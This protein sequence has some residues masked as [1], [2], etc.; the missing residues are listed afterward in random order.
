MQTAALCYCNQY[1]TDGFVPRAV[2]A[3]LQR[4]DNIDVIDDPDDD[5]SQATRMNWQ[6]AAS[7]STRSRPQCRLPT[8]THQSAR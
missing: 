7:V 8:P 5:Q 3:K 2:A 1:L 6:P 4:F